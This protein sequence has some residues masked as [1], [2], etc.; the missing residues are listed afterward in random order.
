MVMHLPVVALLN[1][2]SEH[3]SPDRRQFAAYPAERQIKVNGGA[4][5][6]QTLN[7]NAIAL[8]LTTA[9]QPRRFIIP[10]STAGLQALVELNLP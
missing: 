1:D 4:F 7:E 5:A 9:L 8:R 6:P 10:P 2:H 3:S